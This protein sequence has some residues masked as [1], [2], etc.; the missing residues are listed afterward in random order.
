[1]SV[2]ERE[3]TENDKEEDDCGYVQNSILPYTF[4]VSAVYTMH[5]IPGRPTTTLHCTEHS[6]PQCNMLDLTFQGEELM[7]SN[8]CHSISLF[9]MV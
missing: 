4:S 2:C 8:I 9:L 3:R 7:V 1:M 5:I 6:I